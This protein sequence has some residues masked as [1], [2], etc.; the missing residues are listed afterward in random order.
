MIYAIEQECSKDGL[1]QTVQ[2]KGFTEMKTLDGDN[3]V[4]YRACPW[5]LGLEWYN[6]AMVEFVDEKTDVV[7]KYPSL[8]LG[9][10]ELPEGHP[11]SIGKECT[12]YA[13]VRTANDKLEC[14]TLKE[15]FVSKFTLFVTTMRVFV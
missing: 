10:I 1:G 6:F 5:Y 15:E 4:L 14:E 13:V 12:N 8:L 11:L 3:A 7:Q 9:F 2:V